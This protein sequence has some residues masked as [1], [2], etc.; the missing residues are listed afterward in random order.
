MGKIWEKTLKEHS[1][2]KITGIYDPGMG[3]NLRFTDIKCD[4]AI[5][6]SPTI[7]HA[8]YAAYYA[9]LGVPVMVEKPLCKTVET[10]EFLAKP[11]HAVFMSA[12]QR[13]TAENIDIPLGG[14][15]FYKYSDKKYDPKY[16]G[17]AWD[18]AIHDLDLAVSRGLPQGKA[19]GR[20]WKEGYSFYVGTTL[21]EGAYGSEN[22]RAE[23]RVWR[24]GVSVP[25]VLAGLGNEISRQLHDFVVFYQTGKASSLLCTASQAALSVRILDEL[26][27]RGT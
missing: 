25:H 27:K 9:A 3:D 2:C 4:V 21:F 5:V 23:C 18:L 8:K 13:Y 11:G 10:A 19:I 6:A 24:E 14:A 20:A 17:A 12:P 22:R 15:V 26:S 1:G 16:E 7:T